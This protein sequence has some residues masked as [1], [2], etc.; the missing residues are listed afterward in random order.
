MLPVYQ[1]VSV[2][3]EAIHSGSTKPCMMTLADD[4]GNL[5]GQFVVKVF[6]PITLEQSASTN[7]EV[8]GSILARYFD[9]NTPKAVL[10]FISQDIIEIL[11][12]HRRDKLV[13][14]TY[15]ATEYIENAL[16]YS[17]TTKLQLEDWEVENIFA[18]DVLIRNVDRH[19]GKPNLF[20]K[21][22]EV[23]LIDHELSLASNSLDKTFVEMLKEM[24]KYWNFIEIVQT[25]FERKHIFLENL[26]ERNKKNPIEFDTFAEYLRTFN[27]DILD[28]YQQQLQG[29]GND[30]EDFYIIK[31][32]LT[33]VKNNSNLF[34]QLLKDLIS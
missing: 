11:N 16:D 12:K 18:F 3:L 25:G 20:F 7:K 30:T 27:I 24:E 31:S 33:E 13:R 6:K 17:E 28:D 15:F 2:D 32:Y 8:Y 21:N 10:A 19:K 14:G 1:A 9:L 4:R 5:I 29:L 26:R 22:Q 34:I 23:Y